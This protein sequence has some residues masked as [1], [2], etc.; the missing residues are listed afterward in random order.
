MDN[1]QLLA[2]YA[3]KF[4]GNKDIYQGIYYRADGSAVVTN[5]HMALRI[6][7]A[8]DMAHATVLHAKTG[9]PLTGKYPDVD[10]V[11]PASSCEKI[12]LD[13]LEGVLLR[14]RCA[15]DVAK[16]LDKK[17]PVALLKVV[18]GAAY[19]QIKTQIEFSALFGTLQGKESL[20][21]V[22]PEYLHTVLSVFQDSGS[23][24]SVELRHPFEPIVLTDEADIDVMVLPYRTAGILEGVAS[25]N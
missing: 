13:G 6:R 22:N 1:Q 5:R 8:H 10:R 4:A 2:K 12:R 18:G 24:V 19:L 14:T 3:K 23:S 25:E 17:L 16:V 15:T 7:N 21:A 9:V 20:R 11:F